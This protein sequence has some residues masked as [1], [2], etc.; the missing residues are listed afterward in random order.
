VQTI[1]EFHFQDQFEGIDLRIIDL[2]YQVRL[3]KYPIKPLVLGTSIFSFNMD[4]LELDN[5]DNLN[6]KKILHF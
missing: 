5:K 3:L 2:S 4:I 1:G 6:I